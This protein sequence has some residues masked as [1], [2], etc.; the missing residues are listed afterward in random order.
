MSI[1]A[2]LPEGTEFRPGD[3]IWTL[4]TGKIVGDGGRILNVKKVS[5]GRN[6]EKKNDNFFL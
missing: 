3:G 5:W 6:L 4:K 1:T 2:V